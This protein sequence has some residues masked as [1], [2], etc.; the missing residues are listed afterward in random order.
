MKTI[1][2]GPDFDRPARPR[3][4]PTLSGTILIVD[5]D[6][7]DARSLSK[8]LREAG[9]SVVSAS[10]G[11]EGLV[12]ARR[13]LPALIVSEISLSGISG[14]EMCRRLRADLVTEGIQ[15]VM[16]SADPSDIDRV[17]GFECGADDYVLKPYNPRELVLRIRAVL[18]RAVGWEGRRLVTVGPITIDHTR[19]CVLVEGVSVALTPI[20]FKL[21][22]MLAERPN[23][24]QTRQTLLCEVW[25]DEEAI[26]ERS[27]DSYLRRL[28]SKLGV[29][30]EQIKTVYGFGYRM[31]C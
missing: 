5:H 3:E 15:L 23:V 1:G 13:L 28:R 25:G 17:L 10:S 16:L 27:V 12:M 22:S 24:I 20:E 26:A 29:A 11:E 31:T 14:F 7:G 30:G 21:L 6:Q 4:K 18:R 19:T 2:G 9:F 8:N